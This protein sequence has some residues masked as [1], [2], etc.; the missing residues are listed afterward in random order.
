MCE[1]Y[2]CTVDLQK[3][4][5]NSN[6]WVELVKYCSGPI[7]ELFSKY[8]H[9]DT[10]CVLLSL[11]LFQC[12][13]LCH[14][15]FLVI[16]HLSPDVLRVPVTWP[17]L[18]P[19]HLLLVP[20]LSHLSPHHTHIQLEYKYRPLSHSQFPDCQC[21][22]TAIEGFR[23]RPFL[24]F[25][26]SKKSTGWIYHINDGCTQFRWAHSSAQVLCMLTRWHALLGHLI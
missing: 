15:T 18:L 2:H 6:V 23:Y 12:I 16:P 17:C 25:V 26:K 21:D 13:F 1:M 14:W 9:R 11:P 10:G 4:I 19:A 22:L 3:Q 8:H 7:E 24:W 5:N 20:L